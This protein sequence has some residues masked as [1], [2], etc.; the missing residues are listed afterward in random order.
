AWAQTEPSG[1]ATVHAADARTGETVGRFTAGGKQANA[2]LSDDGTVLVVAASDP[3]NVV[4]AFELPAAGPLVAKSPTPAP[5]PAP[6]EPEPSDLKMKWGPVELKTK[7]D[8]A[9]PHFDI[10]G[11]RVVVAGSEPLAAAVVDA[12]TGTVAGR[13]L[14]NPI[15][16]GRFHRLFR[17]DGGRLGFQTET[18]GS[19]LFWDPAQGLPRPRSFAPPA[20][21]GVPVLNVSP[22]GRFFAVWTAPEAAEPPGPLRVTDTTIHKTVT[23]DWPGGTTAFT[24]DSSRLL[25]AD[26]AGRFRW[27]KLPGGQPDGE[28]WTLGLPAGAAPQIMGLSADGGLILFHGRP[29]GKDVS[30]YLLDGKTGAVIHSF[31]A[32]RYAATGGAVSADGQRV[33]LVRDDGTGT[34][35]AVVVFDAAGKRLAA[36]RFP[37]GGGTA[38]AVAPDL[39]TAVLYDPT[40][41]KLTAYDIPTPEPPGESP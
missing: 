14:L 27:F 9:T 32:K 38:A 21:A 4:Q 17:L 3:D 18:D 7:L 11:R 10:D 22:N 26:T 13:E 40:G 15:L 5:V 25:V 35:R 41:N 1:P 36:G 29:T 33:A 19:V 23:I 37:A 34:A 8:A 20:G 31:P 6:P 16:K 24:A 30:A 12:K 28:G 39:R 2:V